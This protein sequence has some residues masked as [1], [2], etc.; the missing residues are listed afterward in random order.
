[1]IKVKINDIDLHYIYMSGKGPDPIPLILSHGW[2]GSIY[3]FIRIIGPLTD[4]TSYGGNSKDAFTIIAPSLPGYGFSQIHNSKRLGLNE[5]AEVFVKLMT[6]VLG[7]S[8]FAG[9]GGDW[10]P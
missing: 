8:K 7:F 9:Q 2:P 4:P 1:M 5:V 3:E 10:G 6:E